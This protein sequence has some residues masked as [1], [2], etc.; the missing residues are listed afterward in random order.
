MLPILD[1][2]IPSLYPLI[3]LHAKP[4]DVDAS[5]KKSNDMDMDLDMLNLPKIEKYWQGKDPFN[6]LEQQVCMLGQSYL[7]YRNIAAK[8]SSGSGSLSV[9]AQ[10]L[11]ELGKPHKEEKR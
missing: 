4:K 3:E 8:S 5:P 1:S 11:K 10:S 9:Q 7:K 2:S 6:L